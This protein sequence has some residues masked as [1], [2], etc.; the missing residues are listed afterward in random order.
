MDA[1]KFE[2]TVDETIAGAMPELRPLF[3]RRVEV[4]ALDSVSAPA[5]GKRL[6]FDD[7]L[8]SR[9]QRPD[10]VGPV[11]LEDMVCLD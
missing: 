2:T 5:R 8:A 9:L 6:S 1:I 4:I 11:S 3:G 10:N 7:F